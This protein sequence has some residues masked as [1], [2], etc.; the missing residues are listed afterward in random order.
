MLN[1]SGLR[2]WNTSGP[3]PPQI[4]NT[5]RFMAGGEVFMSRKCSRHP[6]FDFFD[7]VVDVISTGRVM[8]AH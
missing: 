2:T 6:I 3:K 8:T 1:P 5:E 7:G 4:P